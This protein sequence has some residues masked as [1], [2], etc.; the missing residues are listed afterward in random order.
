[1]ADVQKAWMYKE[2]GNFQQVLKLEQIDVPEIKPHE[3]L[4]KVHAAGLNPFDFKRGYGVIKSFDSPLPHVPG[5]DVAG[6]VVKVGSQVSKFKKGDEVYGDINGDIVEGQA[7]QYGTLAQY[8]AVEE[9]LLALKP[10]NLSFVEAASLPLAILTAQ[11]GLDRADLQEGQSLLVTGGAGGVGSLV[12][13]LAKEVYGALVVAATASTKKLEFLKSIG[14]DVAIDYTKENYDELP[15]KYDVVYDS[16]GD[17][18]K[19]VKAVRDGGKVIEIAVFEVEPPAFSFRLVAK[20]E[21]LEKLT[22]YIESGKVKPILDPKAPYKFS[23]VLDAFA[24]LETGRA[25]G[26]VVIALIE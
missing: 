23:D 11:E 13:Q 6:V 16:I 5:F 21:N 4:V 8:T 2:Y 22:P 17:Y 18:P 24:Y 7:R 3:V 9:K 20:G 1:M 19:S 15:D 25:T 26:K 10:K 14:A 12:I